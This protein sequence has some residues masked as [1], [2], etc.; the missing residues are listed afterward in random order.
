MA[1]CRLIRKLAPQ[2]LG[3]GLGAA[4]IVSHR[5]YPLTIPTQSQSGIVPADKPCR[6]QRGE[7]LTPGRGKS[8]RRL[9]YLL[10]VFVPNFDGDY[11]LIAIR[12][13]VV[14]NIMQYPERFDPRAIA[15]REKLPLTVHLGA[16]RVVQVE[17]EAFH[18]LK[19][20]DCVKFRIPVRDHCSKAPAFK[21]SDRHPLPGHAGECGPQNCLQP[22][23]ISDV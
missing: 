9:E 3:N 20:P 8:E 15:R 19:H 16:L 17:I 5:V 2:E 12:H 18:W 21:G 6:R 10:P 13:L 22:P 1:P 11:Y 7:G 4:F 14:G 23:P